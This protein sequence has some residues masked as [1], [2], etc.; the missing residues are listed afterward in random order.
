[1]NHIYPDQV[2]KEKIYNNIFIEKDETRKIKRKVKLRYGLTA[3]ALCFIFSGTVFAEEIKGILSGLMTNYNIISEYV[4]TGIYK[5]SDGHVEFTIEE[6]MSDK[7][8]TRAVIKYT[9]L[10]DVGK[11]WMNNDIAFDYNS[12]NITPVFKDDN[13]ALYGVNYGLILDELTE[14]STETERYFEIGVKASSDE[15]G[16][17]S[18]NIRY[19]LYSKYENNVQINVAESVQLMD[20]KFDS[21]KAPKKFY[22]PTGAKISPLS[23]FVYGK[24]M[25]MTERTYSNTGSSIITINEEEIDSLNLILRDNQ[26]IDLLEMGGWSLCCSANED[27]NCSIFCTSFEEPIDTDTVAGIELDGVYYPI[28]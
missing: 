28:E 17:D 11:E 14:Y 2:Q 27:Y 1:M 21:S 7:I 15:F 24:D 10:D 23:I 12:F 8:T 4:F 26:K 19:S 16:T 18:V 25:G 13:T 22:K 9:A 20:F 3:I 6:L 5:D